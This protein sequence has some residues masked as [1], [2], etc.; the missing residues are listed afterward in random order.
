MLRL[1]RNLSLQK[2]QVFG[3]RRISLKLRP[4]QQRRHQPAKDCENDPGQLRRCWR[5]L[6]WLGW[7]RRSGRFRRRRKWSAFR[8]RY[9][10]R[11]QFDS[12]PRDLYRALLELRPAAQA[13]NFRSASGA[14]RA[15]GGGWHPSAGRFDFAEKRACRWPSRTSRRRRNRCHCGHRWFRR[16]V[17]PETCRAECR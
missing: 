13:K 7:R 2:F 5:R 14:G 16:A 8:A 1:P 11:A 17:A 9:A 6:R 15:A 4:I 12:A 3:G 10:A